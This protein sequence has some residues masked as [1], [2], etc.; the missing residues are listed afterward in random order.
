MV[1]DLMGISD[2]RSEKNTFILF[3]FCLSRI[4]LGI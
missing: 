3:V 2:F 4:T 1:P